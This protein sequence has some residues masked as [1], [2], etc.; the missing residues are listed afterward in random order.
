MFEEAFA[1]WQRL[2]SL[3]RPMPN[4][5]HVFVRGFEAGAKWQ[6]EQ[7]IAQRTAYCEDF[8]RGYSDNWRTELLQLREAL[9][10]CV[11]ALEQFVDD[12]SCNYD[13]HDDCQTHDL[14]PKPFSIERAKLVIDEALASLRVAS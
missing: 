2:Y 7:D 13:H 3:L 1:E 4:E 12:G 9:Q 11:A 8:V 14:T 10:N 5:Q 6:A